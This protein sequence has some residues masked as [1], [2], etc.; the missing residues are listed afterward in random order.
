VL[1]GPVTGPGAPDVDVFI[2]DGP[3][4]GDSEADAHRYQFRKTK[5]GNLKPANKAIN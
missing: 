3:A 1:P 2:D 4:G 5:T